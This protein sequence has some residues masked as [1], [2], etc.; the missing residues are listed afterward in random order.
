MSSW[1]NTDA[2][3][4]APLWALTAVKK[5]PTA[6]NMGAAGSGKLFN[7]ATEDNLITD[8]T[9]GLFNFKDTETQSGKVAHAGWNMKVTGTGGRASRVQYET[10]VA[11]TNSADA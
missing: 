6:A 7:N 3:G 9:I 1:K 2:H 5:A 11:L 4:S 10:L 8:V